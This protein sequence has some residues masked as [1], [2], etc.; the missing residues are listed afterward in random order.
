MNV[1]NPNASFIDMTMPPLPI[2]PGERERICPGT[3]PQPQHEEDGDEDEEISTGI[4][5]LIA[6]CGVIVLLVFG[7]VILKGVT[8]SEIN[9]MRRS[10]GNEQ[11]TLK[12]ALNE[13]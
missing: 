5:V 13:R 2:T 11:I 6:I 9:I 4:M 3:T 8:N 1:R 7:W 12:Q 10:Y